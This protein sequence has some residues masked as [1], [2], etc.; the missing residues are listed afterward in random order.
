MD[1]ADPAIVANDGFAVLILWADADD[2][3]ILHASNGT[4]QGWCGVVTPSGGSN[5]T[6]I[7]MASL[8]ALLG[9]DVVGLV[10]TLPGTPP[11]SSLYLALGNLRM[12]RRAGCA[13]DLGMSGLEAYPLI[14][15]IP[16]LMSFYHSNDFFPTFS[17]V[18]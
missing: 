16:W 5:I 8:G 7:G 15:L 11:P 13:F 14:S 10:Q 2:P 9:F 6:G 18:V 12:L 1:E 3:A 4:I 17:P